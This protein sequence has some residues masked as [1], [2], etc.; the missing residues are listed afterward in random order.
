MSESFNN[1]TTGVGTFFHNCSTASDG[2]IFRKIRTYS[3][4]VTIFLKYQICKIENNLYWM[5]L[6]HWI[7]LETLT[8]KHVLKT[9]HCIWSQ[10]I[11]IT[12]DVMDIHYVAT[13]TRDYLNVYDGD[14]QV[15]FW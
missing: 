7:G 8:S 10:A 6:Q 13:C 4:A 3:S 2:F 12:F 1:L 5:L 15:S 9:V 11:K 14:E